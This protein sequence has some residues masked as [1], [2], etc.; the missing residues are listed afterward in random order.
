MLISDDMYDVIK[1]S[2][3]IPCI[4][5]IIQ[6]SAGEVLLLKRE[7]EPAKNQWWFP[8]GRIL[9][10]ETRNEAV[11]RKIKQE[12]GISGTVIEDLGT[13]DLFLTFKSTEEDQVLSHGIST[14]FLV[15]VDSDTIQLDNQSSEYQ[16]CDRIK[17]NFLISNI[18]LKEILKKVFK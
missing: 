18:V 16:W 2:F 13:F 7:N 1:K 17:S 11:A 3:P 14:F 10:G 9:F 15:R 12:C 5:L 6:N 4:D 8:G